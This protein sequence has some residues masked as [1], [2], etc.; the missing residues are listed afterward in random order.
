MGHR[1]VTRRAREPVPYGGFETHSTTSSTTRPYDRDHI[2]PEHTLR[3]LCNP[4]TQK[5]RGGIF[6][7][8]TGHHILNSNCALLST[9]AQRLLPASKVRGL[10][11]ALLFYPSRVAGRQDQRTQGYGHGSHAVPAGGEQTHQHAGGSP[12][13]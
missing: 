12:G 8:N 1:L 2:W 11:R 4:K 5:P 7:S 3:F 10:L 9:S 13:V 6:C